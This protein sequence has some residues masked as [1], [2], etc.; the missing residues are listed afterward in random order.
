MDTM[1]VSLPDIETQP[2]AIDSWK[3]ADCDLHN[4]I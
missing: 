1:D 3:A 4:G 2:N